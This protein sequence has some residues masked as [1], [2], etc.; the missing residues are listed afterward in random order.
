MTMDE[1]NNATKRLSGI[2]ELAH[3]V[4]C[5]DLENYHKVKDADEILNCW[6]RDLAY[7]ENW[8][9]MY[10]QLCNVV[11]DDDDQFFSVD[12]ETEPFVTLS[13]SDR[14]WIRMFLLEH[15]RSKGM[16]ED[17]PPSQYEWKTVEELDE[18]IF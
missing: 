16:I 10:S 14:G 11:F 1:F 17:E 18:L 3:D 8:Y 2:I 6:M 15:M 5:P 12:D 13:E 4:N 9:S 7:T